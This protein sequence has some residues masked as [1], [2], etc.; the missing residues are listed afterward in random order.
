MK[1]KKKT[2]SSFTLTPDAVRR[3]AVSCGTATRTAMQPAGV[4]ERVGRIAV[5]RVIK[6]TETS[7]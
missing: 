4:R 7:V 1:I 5:R 2:S 3:V 6:W